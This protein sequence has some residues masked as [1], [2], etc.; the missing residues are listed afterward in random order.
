[1]RTTRYEHPRTRRLIDGNA[2]AKRR[3]PIALRPL[4]CFV[5][6]PLS[7]RTGRNRECHAIPS[8]C[9]SM[10]PVRAATNGW[11]ARQRWRPPCSAAERRAR[12]TPL[13]AALKRRRGPVYFLP[14]LEPNSLAMGIKRGGNN[15]IIAEPPAGSEDD[16]NQT[17]AEIARLKPAAVFVDAGDVSHD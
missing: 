13:A 14:Q 3:S 9:A 17:L 11:P 7:R 10:R 16:V 6:L 15:W 12:G 8:F 2:S 5:R 1:H 4:P